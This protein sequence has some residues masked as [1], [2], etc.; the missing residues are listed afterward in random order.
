LDVLDIEQLEEKSSSAAIQNSEERCNTPK[1]HPETHMSVINQI[2]R[3]AAQYAPVP[4]LKQAAGT[5]LKILTT[6]QVCLVLDLIMI[7]Q[8]PDNC[9]LSRIMRP[10]FNDWQM[11]SRASSRRSGWHI[12]GFLK[13]KKWIGPN[14][15]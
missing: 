11:M 15:T 14:K 4:Y 12:S 7:T 1:Y 8:Q 9:S 6:V 3:E 2:L 5:T 13:M 10:I